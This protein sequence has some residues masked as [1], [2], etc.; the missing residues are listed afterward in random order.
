[1]RCGVNQDVLWAAAYSDHIFLCSPDLLY[2][3]SNCIQ[4]SMQTMFITID[5]YDSTAVLDDVNRVC[6]Y[7]D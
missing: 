6:D 4:A 7:S 1:M 2:T 5:Y 3:K